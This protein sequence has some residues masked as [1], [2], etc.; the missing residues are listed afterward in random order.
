MVSKEKTTS[1][2]KVVKRKNNLYQKICRLEN[3][4]L[5]DK[6]ARKGKKYQYGIKVH[7]KNKEVNLMHL[8]D[9]LL[10][11][12]YKTSEYTT[13]KIYEPKERTVFRLP[14]YPDRITH[15]AILNVL[16]PIF[17]SVFTADTYSCIKGK[18]IHAASFALRKALR[19]IPNTTYC[20]KLD[21]LTYS[22]S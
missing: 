16:E 19:D 2:A 22:Q 8:Q 10:S 12:N 5:A 20:L 7:D 4:Q 3:L 6:K 18:G 15:H 9:L 13:F 11:K 1:K 21:I 17:V 14:Y